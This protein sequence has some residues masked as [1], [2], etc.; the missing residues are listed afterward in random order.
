MKKER[1]RKD[2]HLNISL[3]KAKFSWESSD[4]DRIRRKT[5][6]SFEDK[7]RNLH[8]QNHQNL[9]E[10]ALIFAFLKPQFLCFSL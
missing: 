2:T 5:K 8:I 3:E 4:G 10:K 1:K 9:R 7:P 6:T